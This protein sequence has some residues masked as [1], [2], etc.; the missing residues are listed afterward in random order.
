MVPD[1][2][3]ALNLQASVMHREQFGRHKELLEKKTFLDF[4]VS[5]VQAPTGPLLIQTLLSPHSW[6]FIQKPL[7]HLTARTLA[8]NTDL[9]I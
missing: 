3:F 7:T 6:V 9:G 4:R 5:L 2:R 1:I 8:D